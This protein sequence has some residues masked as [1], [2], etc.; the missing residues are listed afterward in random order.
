MKRFFF[1]RLCVSGMSTIK[2]IY[3]SSFSTQFVLHGIGRAANAANRFFGKTKLGRKI[4]FDGRD[5][6]TDEDVY[7]GYHYAGRELVDQKKLPL[8]QLLLFKKDPTLKD[9]D[10]VY[11]TKFYALESDGSV[12]GRELFMGSDQ[13]NR[14]DKHLTKEPVDPSVSTQAFNLSTLSQYWGALR[15]MVQ[16]IEPAPVPQAEAEEHATTIRKALEKP[17]SR[18]NNGPVAR[19]MTPRGP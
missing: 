18:Q 7:K 12:R 19:F 1:K 15:P 14:L 9:A 17:S 3:D 5:V 10:Q 8:S 2:N 4:G 13:I 16:G 11:L 6:F